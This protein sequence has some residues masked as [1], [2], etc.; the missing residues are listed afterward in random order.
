MSKDGNEDKDKYVDFSDIRAG[1]VNVDQSVGLVKGGKKGVVIDKFVGRD[2][3]D[4]GKS[5]TLAVRLNELV[6]FIDTSFRGAPQ[7]REELKQLVAELAEVMEQVPAERADEAEKVVK[8]VVALVGE[9]AA[10][11]PDEEMVKMTGES[12]KRT[13]ENVKDALPIATQIVSQVLTMIR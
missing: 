5:D 13:A 6:G 11:N 12:L 3:I 8:R 9:A 10:D 1:R 4:W 2:Q 7:E